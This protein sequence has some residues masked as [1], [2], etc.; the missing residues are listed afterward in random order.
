VNRGITFGAM[1]IAFAWVVDKARFLGPFDGLGKKRQLA[2][3]CP[4]LWSPRQEPV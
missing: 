2:A 3:D 1:L 4:T